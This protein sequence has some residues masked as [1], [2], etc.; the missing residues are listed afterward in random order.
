[1]EVVLLPGLLCD[2]LLWQSQ[3]AGLGGGADCWVA[4]TTMDETMAE[5]H[6]L[7]EP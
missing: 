1:M 5:A 7:H 3:I 2:A 4:P 6:E